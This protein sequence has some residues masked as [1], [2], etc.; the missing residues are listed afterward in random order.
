MGIIKQQTIKGSIYSYLGILI[1]FLTVSIIQPHSLSAE[2][3]GLISLLG[4]LSLMFAQF[5][6]MGFNGTARYFPY[7]RNEEN[8]HN[9]YLFL[10]CAIS[11]VGS[12]L[13]ITIAYVYKDELVGRNQKSILFEQYYW[14]L[15]PLTIFTLFFNVF[16]LYARMLYNMTTGLILREF[17]K[18]I[19]VLITVLLVYFKLVSFNT[20]MILWF[21]AN[22]IPTGLIIARLIKDNQF[23]LKPNLEFLT[24]DMVRKLV[25]ICFFTI[26]TGASP[27]IIQN[28]DNILI[29]KKLG[30]NHTGVY[31]WAFNFGIIISLPSRALYSI[32][33]TVIAESWKKND[34]ANIRSVYEKSCVNQLISSLFLFILI[35]A[36]VDNIFA[37][38][39]PEFKDGKYTIFFVSLGFFID[40]ATGINLVI[41]ATSKY[42]K[43]DSL[44]NVLLVGVIV[45]AN[46]ILIP[47]YGIT[48]A[49]IA[50]AITFF[51]FNLFRYL[52]ILIKFK[53]QPFKI[54]S[55]LAI[56]TGVLVYYLSVWIIPH[57]QNFII[58]T[59]ARTAFITI[60]YLPTIYFLKLS[61]DIN[62]I[63]NNLIN[64]I[65]R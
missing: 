23:S 21:L 65:K 55:L 20:F 39:P 35:W 42:F 16:D 64:K 6:I 13:F 28:I 7:F 44:F 53:M 63:I 54:E 34:M 8:K 22:I 9:G 12:I 57:I 40:S 3:I 59:I 41:L 11:A 58:D 50:S 48:G 45:I 14:Y 25:G 24:K 60:I 10:S 49:A 15:V 32:A 38:L 1:G 26:L 52:F 19:F 4:S 62:I 51:I 36:N 27:L 33:Y 29:S 2:G 5:S 56:V 18:R 47:I 17:T 37:M 43:Y 30:L 61:D 31:S 46:L